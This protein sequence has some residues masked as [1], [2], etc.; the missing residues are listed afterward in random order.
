MNKKFVN[1]KYRSK[2][3]TYNGYSYD[4]KLEAGYAEQLDWMVKSGEV[5]NW[6]RQHK[7]SLDINGIH[8]CNYYIDFKVYFT[9]GRIEF[10][11]VKGFETDLW[12]MKWKL[13]KALFPD[14]NLVIVK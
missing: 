4:S 14:Y 12:K 1:N 9:D 3:Q 2:R 5:S 10:H 6:E 8:I 13:T 7:I 11:E